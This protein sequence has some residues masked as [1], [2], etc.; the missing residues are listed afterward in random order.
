[1]SLKTRGLDSISATRLT[2][3]RDKTNVPDVRMSLIPRLKGAT[4]VTWI[5]PDSG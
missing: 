4:R 2:G 1:M 5:V 3:R